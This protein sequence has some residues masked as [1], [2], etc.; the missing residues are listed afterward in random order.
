MKTTTHVNGT[1]IA[2]YAMMEEMWSV[3]MVAQTW[4]ISPA[5]RWNQSPQATG[6]A[7]PV[8]QKPNKRVPLEDQERKSAICS[9]SLQLRGGARAA[10]FRNLTKEWN[11]MEIEK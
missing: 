3:A 8:W 11:L 7:N 10:E 1:S 5:S 2:S 6:T 4:R 9:T